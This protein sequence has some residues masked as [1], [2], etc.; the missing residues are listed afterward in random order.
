MPDRDLGRSVLRLSTDRAELVS[1]LV[2]AKTEAADA[3][4]GIQAS[5]NASGAQMTA[6]GRKLITGVTLPIVGAGAAIFKLGSDYEKTLNQIVGLTDVTRDQ[7][8]KI[9]GDISSIAEETGRSPQELAEAFYFVAS[10]GFNAAEATDVLNVSAHAA[11]AG[12][13]QTGDVAK[14][15]GL[16]INAYGKEN[17]TAAKAADILVAAVKDGTA[18]ADAFA[19]VLGRVVPTAATLGVS[20]DQV[21]AALAG[22][23]LT[24]LS[25]DEAAT[26]LNQVLVSLLKPTSAAEAALKGMG[27]SSAQLRE[28]LKDKGLL[29]VLRD[30]ET[31]FNG[32]DDAAAQVFGN[33]RALRGVLSL[34]TV[35]ADQLNGVFADTAKAQGDLARGY[36][37]T[38]GA[39][40]DW[41]RIQVRL[42][43]ALIALGKDVIPTVLD[44][45]TVLVNVL[46]KGVALFQTLPEPI[47]AA[48]TVLLALAALSGPLLFVTGSIVTLT[49]AVVGLSI[50]LAPVALV[51]GG[52]VVAVGLLYTAITAVLNALNI[53]PAPGE[54]WKSFVELIG[55]GVDALS[56]KL[57]QAG[58]DAQGLAATTSAAME[59]AAAD[60]RE[61]NRII[62]QTL[63][64][65]ATAYQRA[66]KEGPESFQMRQRAALNQAITDELDYTSKALAALQQFRKDIEDAFNAAQSA[67]LDAERTQVAIGEKLAELNSLD[68]DYTKNHAK[69]T[70]LQGQQWRL[71][72]DEALA[73]LTALRLHL[74]LIG[75]DI[76]QTAALKSLLASK[77]MKDGLTSKFPETQAAFRAVRDQAIAKLNE[78]AQK[79]GPASKAAA[80]AVAKYLDPA[81]PISP[82]NDA[83]TW[84]AN[85]GNAFVGA[86]THALR[87][88]PEMRAAMGRIGGF[89]EADS[90]PKDP[91]NALHHIDRWGENTARGWLDPFVATIAGAAGALRSPLG[92]AA[93]VLSRPIALPSLSSAA[94]GAGIGAGFSRNDRGRVGAITGIAS[95]TAPGRIGAGEGDTFNL[96]LPDARHTDPWAVLDRLPRYAKQAKAQ[97]AAEGWK[98]VES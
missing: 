64:P 33:V 72:K 39:A 84:G 81:N 3:V 61:S 78:L 5:L 60:A 19:G 85:T 16:T 53:G 63:P 43:E 4:R 42:Q 95:P 12:L 55:A 38:E 36:A 86:L 45:M 41:D 65:V 9:K 87:V 30:L 23:T 8:G 56:S 77:E 26:S 40:R 10:A 7:L 18:E 48:V 68:D 24:G 52:I 71:R 54:K 31:A 91:T 90:P 11:A 29:A 35:D 67:A 46:T 75:D 2:M 1:G 13:G 25:A 58:L 82:F 44:V 66:A 80:D 73:E 59:A 93:A 70:K 47:R 94:A 20:F 89:L 27:L 14:V 96:Y 74:A 92:A 98:V 83:H 69:W 57:D 6:T 49:G 88:T 28:E 97:V 17:I 32:N 51:I 62:R 22:M 37:E 79:G 34:L 21:A 50:S 76:T 15:L